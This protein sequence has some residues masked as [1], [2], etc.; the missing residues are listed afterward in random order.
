MEDNTQYNQCPKIYFLRLG[1]VLDKGCLRVGSVAEVRVVN[2]SQYFAGHLCLFH[3]ANVMPTDVPGGH[4]CTK[5]CVSV[6]ESQ[7]R[8]EKQC[9]PA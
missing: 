6:H 3:Q 4:L 2:R 9:Q 5:H 1:K 7:P 8:V